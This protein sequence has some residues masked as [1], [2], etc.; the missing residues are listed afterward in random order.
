MAIVKMKG[1]RL[2]AMRRDRED[3]LRDLQHTGAVQVE[4]PDASRTRRDWPRPRKSYPRWS[5]PQPC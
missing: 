2:V 3:L 5:G 1:L 4:Q